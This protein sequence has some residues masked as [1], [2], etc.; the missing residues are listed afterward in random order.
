[1]IQIKPFRAIRPTRDKASL[2]GS[3]SYLEY[4]DEDLREKLNNNPYTFLHVINPDFHLDQRLSGREKFEK[5]RDKFRDF[6]RE[7]VFME[8][9]EP[10]LYIYQQSTPTHVFTGIVGAASVKDYQEGRIKKHENT[11][12]HR[13][14]L[15]KD[16]L[17]ITGVNAEPVLLIYPD[18]QEVDSVMGK[19][20]E[21]RPE[22]EFCTTDR[23]IHFLWPI[24]DSKDVQI[25]REGFSRLD[26]LYIADGHH[27]C[28]SSALLSDGKA[29][30]DPENP[31]DWFMA[32]FLPENNIRIHE[33]NRLVQGLNGHTMDSFLDSVSKKFF[34]REIGRKSYRPEGIHEMSMYLEGR[35]FSL[36]VK[37]GSFNSEDP[38]ESLDYEI[39]SRNLLDPILGIQDLRTD[40]RIAFKPGTDG[41]EGIEKAIDRG[42][43]TVGF[44]MFPVTIE[45]LKK[46]ADAQ[47]VMPPK[48]TY[49][50]PKLRSGLTI[51]K[52]TDE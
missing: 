38:V 12:R 43:F 11:L 41:P 30:T 21:L 36:N 40:P 51:Y 34:V 45:Q 50:E 17:E 23:V 10:A 3:R 19:Y 48:S 14:E 26:S 22:Y 28:S 5:V 15:F 39:L 9:P 24:H 33:F 46:V 47:L 25:I 35:W 42:R 49:I 1:M 52:L 20:M 4:S 6:V 44:C 13:E 7:G 18:L 16:Y 2:V 37:P 31:R 32:M 29:S 8:D 27:R